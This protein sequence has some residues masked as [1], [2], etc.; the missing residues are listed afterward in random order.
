M[1]SGG[2]V[3]AL[4][5]ISDVLKLPSYIVPEDVSNPYPVSQHGLL[6]INPL[7][8]IFEFIF[9]ICI[10][11]AWRKTEVKWTPFVATDGDCPVCNLHALHG[12][13]DQIEC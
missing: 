13:N 9:G 5:L 12:Q 11:L 2:V 1:L 4:I 6:Y 7:S 3:I 8:R 10:A